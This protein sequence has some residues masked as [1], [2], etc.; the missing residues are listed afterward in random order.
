M[1]RNEIS[2]TSK[3]S[4]HFQHFFYLDKHTE[5]KKRIKVFPRSVHMRSLRDW[6]PSSRRRSY[7]VSKS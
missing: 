1:V 3:P 6:S 5:I 4:F 7:G 2:L